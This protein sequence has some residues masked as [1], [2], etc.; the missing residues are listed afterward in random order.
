[1][2]Q[3]LYYA[4]QLVWSYNLWKAKRV[5][6]LS[7]AEGTWPS[8]E[9]ISI[10]MIFRMNKE[11][12]KSKPFNLKQ[13][14]ADIENT[15]LMS[16]GKPGTAKT[17]AGVRC[18]EWQGT[19]KTILQF[20]GGGFLGGS[21]ESHMGYS[22]ELSRAT[23]Y[24]VVSVDYRMAPEHA[25]PAGLEDCVHVYEGL[26]AQKVDPN[27]IVL[28]GDSAGGGMVLLLLQALKKK[29]VSMP[30]SAVLLSAL[31]DLSG[32]NLAMVNEDRDCM[33]TRKV[34]KHIGQV[35]CGNIN[36][37]GARI[38]DHDAKDATWSAHYGS[39]EGLPPLFFIAGESEIMSADTVRTA[40]KA[41]SAGVE[42]K[43]WMARNMMHAFPIYSGCFPES[44]H[45]IGRIAEFMEHH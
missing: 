18:V 31:T 22:F 23:G 13:L 37:Q 21:P 3:V 38:A 40:E 45:A 12:N 16:P 29:G 35:A 15:R 19:G 36:E 20:H 4:I 17:I 6:Q 1:M 33:V 34:L 26:L 44:S 30:S 14:R 42:V 24:T 32:D 2:E 5:K 11:R 43:V 25:M 8:D 41:E 7:W 28:T 10:D 9:Y 39:F 27:Q